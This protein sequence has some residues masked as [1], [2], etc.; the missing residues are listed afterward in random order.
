[1]PEHGR[2]HDEFC[3][4]LR[5]E[6]ELGSKSENRLVSKYTKGMKFFLAAIPRM[7]MCKGGEY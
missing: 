4:P 5:S 3:E 6:I 1:M 2:T 7:S